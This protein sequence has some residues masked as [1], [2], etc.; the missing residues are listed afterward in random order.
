[1][2]PMG[3]CDENNPFIE[4]IEEKTRTFLLERDSFR[5]SIWEQWF[6]CCSH[7]LKWIIRNTIYLWL[8]FEILSNGIYYNHNTQRNYQSRIWHLWNTHTDEKYVMCLS[9]DSHYSLLFDLKVGEHRI[10]CLANVL[11]LVW[12]KSSADFDSEDVRQVYLSAVVYFESVGWTLSDDSKAFLIH[13]LHAIPLQRKPTIEQTS[14]GREFPVCDWQLHKCAL[15]LSQLSLYSDEELIATR[16][17]DCNEYISRTL[18][19]WMNIRSQPIAFSASN[20]PHLIWRFYRIESKIFD[21]QLRTSGGMRCHNTSDNG[22]AIVRI[23]FVKAIRVS[24]ECCSTK[25]IMIFHCFSLI[26]S[27][28]YRRTMYP[29]WLLWSFVAVTDLLSFECEN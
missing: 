17:R 6:E 9:K 21:C 2:K 25:S 1:M 4:L 27:D 15:L 28:K 22:F 19:Q 26:Y 11:P 29:W 23:I 24:P 10:L 16:H 14:S 13:R 3:D 12:A 5:H 8:R 7:T 18:P 20:Y